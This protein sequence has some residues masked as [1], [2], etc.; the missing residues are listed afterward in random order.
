MLLYQVLANTKKKKRKIE[1]Y[2]KAY[3]KSKFKIL[4]PTLNGKFR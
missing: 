3:K 4:A 1:Q 2:K